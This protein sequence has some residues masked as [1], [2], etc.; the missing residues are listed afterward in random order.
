MAAL[1]AKAAVKL[2]SVKG[3]AKYPKQTLAIPLG[4]MC[5][6]GRAVAYDSAKPNVEA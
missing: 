4:S 6:T 2:N 5:V 3:S 1:H